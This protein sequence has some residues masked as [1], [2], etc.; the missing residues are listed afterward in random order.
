MTQSEAIAERLREVLLDGHWIAN[1]NTRAQVEG[2]TWNQATQKIGNLNTIAALTYHLNYYLAGILNVFHG[3]KLEIRDKFSFDAPP[4]ASEE[5]W[6]ALIA[7]FTTNSEKCIAHVK[8][9]EDKKLNDIFVDKKYGT[10]Q[11]NIE[12]IISHSYYHL[13]QITLLKKMILER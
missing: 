7:E 6:N 8:L 10:Y 5:D 13:G 12:G 1:T 2:I 9:M 4:I 3:G 11:R